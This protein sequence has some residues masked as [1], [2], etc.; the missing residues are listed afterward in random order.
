LAVVDERPAPEKPAPSTGTASSDAPSPEDLAVL[1]GKSYPSRIAVWRLSDGKLLLK[2][3]R[4]PAGT[5]LL[6]GQPAKDP[7]AE[8]ARLRQAQSCSLALEVRKAIGDETV[9]PKA[10]DTPAPPSSADAPA[11]DGS[12]APSASAPPST[13]SSASAPPSTPSGQPKAPPGPGHL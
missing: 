4:E 11:A 9:G 1:D 7:G 12:T 2:L 10:E 3:R 13:S 6:G 8:A 5:G